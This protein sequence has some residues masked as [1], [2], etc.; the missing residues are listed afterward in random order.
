MYPLALKAILWQ[1]EQQ[2]DSDSSRAR[3][4][5]LAFFQVL[6]LLEKIKRQNA[7]EEELPPIAFASLP[8]NQENE[9]LKR[10][11][12]SSQEELTED[13]F[14]DLNEGAEVND[15]EGFL[16]D[17][18]LARMEREANIEETPEEDEDEDEEDDIDEEEL[19]MEDPT[20]DVIDSYLA[21]M[22]L[23]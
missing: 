10:P 21:G 17:S 8:G 9:G 4:L 12:K 7:G 2:C 15:P 19:D 22:D 6:H 1:S 20:A 16:S 5:S 23:L 14:L 11:R 18:E 13:G 3:N